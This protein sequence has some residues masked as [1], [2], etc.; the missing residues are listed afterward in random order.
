MLLAN[1][2]VV[3]NSM[4]QIKCGGRQKFYLDRW[5]KCFCIVWQEMVQQ[6]HTTWRNWTATSWSSNS[7][8]TLTL[9]PLIKLSYHW[10]VRPGRIHALLVRDFFQ[11][12]LFCMPCMLT[13]K[14]KYVHCLDRWRLETIAI[15]SNIY[16]SSPANP[17]KIAV[18]VAA[19]HLLTTVLLFC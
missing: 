4:Q 2:L 5:R 18:H 3:R 13:E 6:H 11:C 10:E 16:C 12:Q 15:C 8:P 9:K 17:A 1:H 7:T 19:A 14:F